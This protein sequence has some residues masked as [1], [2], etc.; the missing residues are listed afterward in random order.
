MRWSFKI[1][2]PQEP[3]SQRLDTNIPILG[4][5]IIM[6]SEGLQQR[7]FEQEIVNTS[8]FWIFRGQ[9]LSTLTCTRPA[10]GSW[11]LGDCWCCVGGDSWHH[12]SVTVCQCDSVCMLVQESGVMMPGLVL[13]I[14]GLVTVAG[15]GA[16]EPSILSI[17][18]IVS[19]PPAGT[20]QIS[21][22]PCQTTCHVSRVE[23]DTCGCEQGR[24]SAW[25]GSGGSRG[26]RFFLSCCSQAAAECR[27][28]CANTKCIN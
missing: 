26:P 27:P 12:D 6:Q 11:H 24:I 22:P 10:A 14:T 8:T 25:R 17:P 20:R 13:A 15:A 7:Q 9:V 19:T 21:A 23:C 16:G 1:R 5:S 28:H 4:R 2:N 3:S 18:S